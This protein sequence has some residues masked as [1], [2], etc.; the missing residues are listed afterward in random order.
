MDEALDLKQPQ[1]STLEILLETCH[2]GREQLWVEPVWCCL[3]SAPKFWP[4]SITK[5][6]FRSTF[7]A[8]KSIFHLNQQSKKENKLWKVEPLEGRII[9]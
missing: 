9:C 5:H 6:I 1:D 8:S 7:G 3:P 4:G 2:E